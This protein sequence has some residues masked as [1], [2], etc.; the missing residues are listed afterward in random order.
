MTR[1]A[2]GAAGSTRSGAEMPRVVAVRNVALS[3]LGAILLV[4]KPAYTG[5]FEDALDAYAGNV[6]VSFALY[7]AAINATAAYG[8]PRL[9]AA[10]L[11]LLA[12]GLFEVTDGFG[13]LENVYDQADLIADAAGVGL[14]VV[15]DLATSRV[16]GRHRE[17]RRPDIGCG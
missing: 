6:A 15:V 9:A 14:A 13:V 17:R 8:R 5:P 7:F 1:S 2:A 10:V 3:V 16:L 11:T 4:L 12:V